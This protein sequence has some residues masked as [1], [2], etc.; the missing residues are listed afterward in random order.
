MFGFASLLFAQWRV[1]MLAFQ[2]P[3]I[4]Q[5]RELLKLV[6]R[7]Q[8]TRFGQEHDFASIT[9][10][11]E[12]QSK[13]PLRRY[14]EFWADYWSVKFPVLEDCT[15]PG[16]VPYFALTSGTT[17]GNTKHIPV[18]HEMLNANSRA[19][20]DLLSFHLVAR[21]FSRIW[22]GKGLLLG[23]STDLRELAP[24]VHCGD[25]SGIEANEIPSW[26]QSHVFPSRDLAL[27]D[28][29]EEKIDRIARASLVEDI[30]AVSGTPNWLLIYFE[31][32]M[33]LR[34]DLDPRI[35]SFYPNLELIIHGG[36]DFKPYARRY[37]ELLEG[38]FAELREVYPASEAFIA[39]ADGKSDQGLRVIADNGVFFEFVPVDELDCAKP[40]RHWFG[41]IQCGVNYAVVLSTCAGLWSYIL[42]DTV[43]FVGLDPPRL[44]VTGRTTY[45]LS[46]FGEHLI[47]SE[48]E[49]AVAFAAG[50][51][52]RSVT[53]FCVA[54]LYPDAPSEI[55]RHCYVV[56]FI[57]GP[58]D[59]A[60]C[61]QF[62]RL[63]DD[64]L[65]SLN[66]DY[67]DHR[68]GDYGLGAPQ[69]RTVAKGALA[70][71]MKSRGMLGGQHKV[72]R[73]I[74][75]PELFESLTTFLESYD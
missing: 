70:A 58:L 31:R 46:A 33:E 25:L 16:K 53:D 49:G 62:A 37:A 22:Q 42:G 27:L 1:W 26:A 72:P 61:E 44:V 30:R 36:V 18:T 3:A 64:K 13:V 39:L 32:L 63:L 10:V 43:R 52:G 24:G 7:A 38:S 23:G 19:V 12:F 55:G 4:A 29:W 20:R 9:S 47:N 51:A 66:A 60:G 40:T 2:H 56:E 17:S 14:E 69:I 54:P 11:A 35:V 50:T 59:G 8:A 6:E 15:W 67:K 41:N 48:I 34:P 73:I 45:W 71:W 74:N 68:Q 75:D 5:E 65:Q 28:D 57:E 21:P